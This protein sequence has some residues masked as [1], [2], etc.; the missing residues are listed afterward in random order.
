M[1]QFSTSPAQILGLLAPFFCVGFLTV[2]SA[3]AHEPHHPHTPLARQPAPLIS[4]S[5][6]ASG[7]SHPELL[8]TLSLTGLANRDVPRL[9]LNSSATGWVNG[10][11]VMW[12]YPQA[13]ATWI[14]YLRETK[15]LNFQIAPDASLC[16]LLTHPEIANVAK[17]LIL[18]ET[19]QRLNALQWA[20]VLSLIHI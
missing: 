15:K 10:V 17:G 14:P 11:P 19:S 4:P 2:E 12:S 16:T 1:P 9:W 6:L 13:D 8:A 5:Y 20:A 18:Y 3:A 7:A